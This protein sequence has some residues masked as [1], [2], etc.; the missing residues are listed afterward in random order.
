MHKRIFGLSLLFVF[1]GITL[2]AQLSLS[3]YSRYGLGSL[4]EPNSTRNFAMGGLGIGV[5]DRGAINRVNPASYGSLQ[6]TT[7]E[8]SLYGGWTQLQT[9]S[10]DTYTGN[11]GIHN[12][13]FA[14][15]TTKNFGLVIGLAPY[16]R[17]GYEIVVQDSIMVDGDMEQFFSV[18]NSSGG[19][20]KVFLGVGGSWFKNRLSA[21]ANINFAFGNS[22]YAWQNDFVNPSFAT[23][24][25]NRK[26]L[27]NGIIP[28]VGVQ[29][30]DNVKFTRKEDQIQVLEKEE[31]KLKAQKDKWA[32]EEEAGVAKEERIQS[33][34]PKVEA[35]QAELQ[36]EIDAYQKQI[37]KLA[38]NERENEKEINNLQKKKSRLQRKSKRAGN[39]I[40][41]PQ[42]DNDKALAIARRRQEQYENA[43]KQ[44]IEK[45]ET[46]AKRIETDSLPRIIKKKDSLNFRVGAIVEPGVSLNGNEL[47]TFNNGA[48]LDTANFVENGS[49]KLPILYGFGASVGKPRKWSAGVD[50]K[51]QDWNQ[52]TYFSD[53]QELNASWKAN[54]G[55]EWI[56]V[57]NAV[58]YRKRIAWRAGLNYESTNLTIDNDNITRMAVTFGMG[59]PLGKPDRSTGIYSRINLGF[60]LG[61][62]GTTDNGL[63]QENFYMFRLGVTLNDRWFLKRK[64]D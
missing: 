50:F 40:F 44:T 23:V 41:K 32:K 60:S 54:V 34:A 18:Y 57:Y 19:L 17:T 28:R 6:L 16:S 39:K 5:A 30:S 37:E 35:K 38:E 22:N 36:V 21:G 56:P 27:L 55:G 26:I 29:Y 64:F 8:L 13:M 1:I 42:S 2:Q 63:L 4:F 25:I 43:I 33:K 59:L 14:F 45:R 47:V 7:L 58:K 12:V 48:V 49:V 20:N 31:A 10:T 46:L 15:P 52:F 24:N 51:I 62:H 53:Q 61:R 9:N 3:A 11:G